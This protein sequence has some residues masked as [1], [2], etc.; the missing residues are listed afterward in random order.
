MICFNPKEAEKDREDRNAIIANLEKKIRGRSLTK[1]LTGDAKR[2][3]QIKADEVILNQDKIQK[4]ARYD[5]KYV[6]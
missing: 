2:F 4:E 1:V 6:L 5:G 3:C